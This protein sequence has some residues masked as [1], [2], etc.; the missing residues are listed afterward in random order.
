MLGNSEEPIETSFTSHR[1]KAREKNKQLLKDIKC[2]AHEL[3]YLNKKDD[4]SEY[5]RIQ[6]RSATR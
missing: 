4:D 6:A 2:V 5:P 1:A 3:H